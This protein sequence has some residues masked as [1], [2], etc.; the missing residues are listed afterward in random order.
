[1]AALS[2]AHGLGAGG[3]GRAHGGADHGHDDGDD[4]DDVGA[5]ADDAL[6]YIHDIGLVADDHGHGGQQMVA[7]LENSLKYSPEQLAPRDN[8]HRLIPQG[9]PWAEILPLQS[10]ALALWM[11]H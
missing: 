7:A 11:V 10:T 4:D 1:L 9:A 2:V 8:A 5:G 6:D 3:G